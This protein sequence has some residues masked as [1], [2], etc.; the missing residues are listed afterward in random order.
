MKT[1]ERNAKKCLGV[2]STKHQ[3]GSAVVVTSGVD[4]VADIDANRTP[5]N[6]ANVIERPRDTCIDVF[7]FLVPPIEVLRHRPVARIIARDR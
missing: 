4:L 2:E 6:L 5:P 3:H 1:D 7:L